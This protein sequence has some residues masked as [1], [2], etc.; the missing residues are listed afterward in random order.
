MSNLLGS[1]QTTLSESIRMSLLHSATGAKTSNAWDTIW[2][3]I[4]ISALSYITQNIFDFAMPLSKYRDICMSCFH[5]KHKLVIEGRTSASVSAYNTKMNVSNIYTNDYKAVW[6]FILKTIHA[7]PSIYSVREV[8]NTN[9]IYIDE[10]YTSITEGVYIVSQ[11]EP[12]L[13]DAERAI[14][15]CVSEHNDNTDDKVVT[16]TNRVVIT[17]YSYRSSVSVLKSFVESLTT[18]YLSELADS[19]FGKRFI[20]SLTKN[21][22]SCS[23]D[24]MKC[25]TETEFRSSKTFSNVFFDNKREVLD[26]IDFFL[27]NREWYDRFGIPYTLGIGLYGPPGTGKTSFIKALMNYVS[28]RHLINMPMGL[29]QTKS[30]LNDFYYESRFSEHNKANSVGFDRKIVVIEDMDCAGD[31]VMERDKRPAVSAS[32]KSNSVLTAEE[33]YTEITLNDRLNTMDAEL[34]TAIQKNIA[35]ESRKLASKLTPTVE[36]RITLDD[37]LNLWDGIRETPGRILIISSNHYE[38]LDSALRRPGRI[39]ITLRLDN[40]SRAIIGEMF[41]HFYGTSATEESLAEIPSGVY[42]PAEIVN[43][44]TQYRDDPAGFLERLRT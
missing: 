34:K 1:I 37:I 41:A 17:I 38:K 21:A 33:D 6:N 29:I 40:A 43:I 15:A 8:A 36:D 22:Y 31:I 5:R 25:W 3:S 11:K 24:A 19:R 13:L 16:R 4:L 18:A 23:S 30:Q 14:Y 27:N 28:D 26:K 42:S 10:D 2:M 32:T 39:D 44:Y 12:F 20:Y 9:R 35:E 7:N